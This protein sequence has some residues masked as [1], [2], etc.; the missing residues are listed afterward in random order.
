VGSFQDVSITGNITLTGI[1]TSTN[2]TNSTSSI[3]G[4]F[5]CSGGLG[6]AGNV[7][8]GG[9]V[10]TTGNVIARSLNAGY[11]YN[12]AG[13]GTRF[14][15]IPCSLSSMESQSNVDDGWVVNAGYIFKIYPNT[16]YGG[17]AQT[18]DNSTGTSF[19]YV[20]STTVDSAESVEVFWL[21]DSPASKISLTGL[22]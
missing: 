2:T 7:M 20:A 8:V 9:N 18:I 4:A 19:I 11:M 6:V 14:F 10:K 16:S 21:V 13:S 22:S 15:P 17:T 3:T 1:Y 12:V 5:I